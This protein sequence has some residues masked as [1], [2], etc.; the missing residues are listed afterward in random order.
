MVRSD[1][2][3]FRCDNWTKKIMFEIVT[4][5]L[6]AICVHLITSKNTVYI[7]IIFLFSAHN[8]SIYYN[9][10]NYVC[11][12]RDWIP[13]INRTRRTASKHIIVNNPCRIRYYLNELNAILNYI[14]K[15]KWITEYLAFKMF[16]LFLYIPAHNKIQPFPKHR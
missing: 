13:R 2:N 9:T 15:T 3:Y 6:I 11:I 1:K 8:Y 16:L 7:D 4:F 12:P 14:K 10:Y 5:L